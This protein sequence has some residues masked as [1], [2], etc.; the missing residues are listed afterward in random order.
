M[1]IIEAA[2][3]EMRE[4]F[5]NGDTV[6]CRSRDAGEFRITPGEILTDAI[7]SMNPIYQSRLLYLLQSGEGD[8]ALSLIVS[9]VFRTV[10]VTINDNLI[11]WLTA[12]K[13]RA[14]EQERTP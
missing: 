14:D 2:K 1:N 5:R 12:E 10:E 13:Y 3:N 6:N 11:Y 7:E 4:M 8:D 9:N